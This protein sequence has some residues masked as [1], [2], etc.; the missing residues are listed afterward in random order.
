MGVHVTVLHNNELNEVIVIDVVYGRQAC[1]T[2]GQLYKP[3]ASIVCVCG[4]G[5]ACMQ[6]SGY[7]CENIMVNTALILD[8]LVHL[9]RLM[10]YE[11][12]I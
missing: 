6:Y 2:A 12:Q 7:H 10:E 1:G 11:Q 4:G 9:V 3:Q 8:T 5:R